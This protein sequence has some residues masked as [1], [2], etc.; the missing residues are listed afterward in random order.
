MSADFQISDRGLF[1]NVRGLFIRSVSADFQISDRGLFRKVRGLFIRCPRIVKLVTFSQ[2]STDFLDQY[3][4]IFRLVRT[5]RG[6]FRL[7]S[8]DFQISAR[9]LL[10]QLHFQINPAD[11][12]VIK[13]RWCPQSET[14][15]I[16]Y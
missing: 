9:G 13:D 12:L 11:F 14:E 4:R 5:V 16:T 10:D 2:K 6:F 1:R 15:P 7:V 8:A 3:L